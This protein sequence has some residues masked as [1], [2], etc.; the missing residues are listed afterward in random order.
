MKK[1]PIFIFLSLFLIMVISTLA[2]GV[3]A[4][5]SVVVATDGKNDIISYEY[6]GSGLPVVKEGQT[7]DIIDIM[8]LTYGLDSNGNA[9]ITL[10]LVGTPTPNNETF[11][12]VVLSSDNVN[13]YAWSGAYDG[14][15]SDCA[16]SCAYLSVNDGFGLSNSTATISG[17]SITWTFPRDVQVFDYQSGFVDVSANMTATANA[18][19]VWT[20]LT[21]TGTFPYSSTSDNSAV[22]TW[23]EDSLDWSSSNVTDTSATNTSASTSDNSTS[24]SMPGL[25]FV[26]VIGVLSASSVVAALVEK[27]KKNK[28][29]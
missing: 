23:W 19:W 29:N 20:V 21:W 28:F 25:D 13:A 22:G 7:K 16:S 24:S 10:T 26:S 12:W 9:T 11:Y 18:T 1:K 8:S 14:S 2:S 15:Q 5:A 4:A 6:T 27:R 17:N 3:S